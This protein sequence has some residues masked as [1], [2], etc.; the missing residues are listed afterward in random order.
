ME[1]IK[2]LR[3][4]ICACTLSYHGT[5]EGHTVMAYSWQFQLQE[6]D[7]PEDNHG[8]ALSENRCHFFLDVVQDW[9][10]KHTRNTTLWLDRSS[11]RGRNRTPWVYPSIPKQWMRQEPPPS[12]AIVSAIGSLIQE[13]DQNWVAQWLA[14]MTERGQQ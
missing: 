9:Q 1:G 12:E 7:I 13:L 8:K 5:L 6:V 10:Q 2:V 4:G 3:V 11:S 14:R